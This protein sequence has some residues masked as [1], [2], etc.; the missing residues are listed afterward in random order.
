MRVLYITGLCLQCNTSAAMSHNSYLKG[1]IENDCEV[2]IIMSDHGSL[3]ID[4]SMPLFAEAKYHVFESLSKLDI[5]KEKVKTLIDKNTILENANKGISG[6]SFNYSGEK[7]KSIRNLARSIMKSGYYIISDYN[8]PHYYTKVWINNASKFKTDIKYN[9]VISNSPPE[10]SHELACNLL[11]NKKVKYDKWIQIWEDPWYQEYKI[12]NIFKEEKKLLS[13]A[14]NIYY[15]SPLTLRYQKKLFPEYKSKM[16]LTTLPYFKAE[17]TLISKRKSDCCVFGYFGDYFSQVRNLKPFYEAV[18]EFDGY[19]YICGDDDENFASTEKIN[20]T[21]RLEV[22]K[23]NK[24]QADTDVLIMLC[25]SKGG[26]IPGKIYHYSATDKPIIFILDGTEM[27]KNEIRQ[28]FG[29]Y[30]RYHFCENNKVDIQ[31]VLMKF[32]SGGESLRSFCVE[33]FSPKNVVK[34]ILDEVFGC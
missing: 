20:V 22:G 2:D 34:Q 16:N 29:K 14:Q 9:L 30:N 23:L 33:E 31:K 28:Y 3:E 6:N 25:N 24:L 26:Q 15:V 1:L 19:A 17:K 7:R 10:S 11:K 18:K 13:Y 32:I 12:N 27:E 8:H 4:E 5:I 21:K